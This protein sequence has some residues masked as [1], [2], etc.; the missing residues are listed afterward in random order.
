MPVGVVLAPM[1]PLLLRYGGALLAIAVLCG[2]LFGLGWHAKGKSDQHIFDRMALEAANQRAEAAETKG[3]QDEITFEVANNYS[4]ELIQL[5][6]AIARLRHNAAPNVAVCA[7]ADSA[8]GI[9]ATDRQRSGACEGTEFYGN[10]L[11]C[12]LRLKGFRE[13]VI[14]QNLPVR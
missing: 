6:A 3:K 12:E 4:N 10:A 11:K 8:G 9:D 5:N 7:T 1:N 14:R 13:F 2:S